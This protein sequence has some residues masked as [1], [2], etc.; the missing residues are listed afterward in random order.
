M[1][2]IF[3]KSLTASAL[4]TLSL[5]SIGSSALAVEKITSL[6]NP[7]EIRLVTLAFYGL[8][9]DTYVPVTEEQL[10]RNGC[11]Y[12]TEPGSDKN[13]ELLK[14]LREGITLSETGPHRFRLRNAITLQ[15]KDN[16]VLNLLISDAGNRTPGVFGTADNEAKNAQGFL[17]SNE[18]MLKSL[19]TWAR[20]N[21]KP[22]QSNDHCY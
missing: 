14:I 7:E 22:H 20:E 12:V 6:P 4:V 11:I 15:L 1:M 21:L 8:H 2:K 3:K 19:R 13:L 16:S 9:I 18:A 5:L 10:F 17:L